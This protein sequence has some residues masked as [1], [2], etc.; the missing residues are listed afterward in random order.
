ME[1]ICRCY[2]GN[3]FFKM[4]GQ[5]SKENSVTETNFWIEIGSFWF[6]FLVYILALFGVLWGI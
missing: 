2:M 1:G 4:K 6:S 3:L 5:I